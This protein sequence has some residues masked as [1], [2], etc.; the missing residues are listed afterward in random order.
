MSALSLAGFDGLEPDEVLRRLE[1]HQ[2]ITFLSI[3]VPASWVRDVHQC[4]RSLLLLL[5]LMLFL[6]HPLNHSATLL[7]L[8]K[9]RRCGIRNA[10]SRHCSATFF[11]FMEMGLALW[12]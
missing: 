10:E 3:G 2:E 12:V 7:L 9:Q 6:T 4:M 5:L 8:L 1:D 11:S